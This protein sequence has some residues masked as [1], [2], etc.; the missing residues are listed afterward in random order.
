[1]A[2]N[3]V[4]TFQPA[5]RRLADPAGKAAAVLL[6][7][8]AG[9]QAALALGA[10]WGSAAYGGSNPGVLPES[11]RATSAVASGVYVL[12]AATA[13]TS[14]VPAALRR[15]ALYGTA[16]LMVVG[17]VMNLASPSLVERSIW[18][19]VTA[20][21]VVLLWKAARGAGTTSKLG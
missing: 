17:A 12:L 13:G 10:P 14:L 2:M 3:L 19:P 21:L 8:V 9:F 20:A 7:G 18:T 15:R 4:A 11:F 1:M 5:R 16:G 6:L